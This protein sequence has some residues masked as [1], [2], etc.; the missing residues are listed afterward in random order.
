LVKHPK[1][2]LGVAYTPGDT[3]ALSTGDDGYVYVM[4]LV[5]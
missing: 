2:L 3:R 5:E 1:P 4:R